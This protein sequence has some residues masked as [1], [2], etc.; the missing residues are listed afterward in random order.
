[1]TTTIGSTIEII[2]EFAVPRRMVHHRWTDAA[3][4]ARWFAPAGYATVSASA[5]PRPGG[6]WEL[7]FRS[8]DGHEY[9]EHGEYREIAPERIVLTLTQTDGDHEN[10]ETSITV[11][12]DDVGTADSPRTRMR[13]RQ[14]GYRSERLR[15]DNEQGWLGCIEELGRDLGDP[16]LP[17]SS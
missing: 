16:V 12:L 17:A 9:V 7:A 15:H 1:M 6:R 4:M 13:F 10:P 5:D 3:A 2:R 11:E 14:S 8:D